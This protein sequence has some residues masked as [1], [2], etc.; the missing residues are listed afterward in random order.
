MV[1]YQC[2]LPAS[3]PKFKK[4][5]SRFQLS[6]LKRNS[7]WQ[8]RCTNNS[9]AQ[10]KHSN[11]TWWSLCNT[12][13]LCYW[14]TGA[15]GK[16]YLLVVPT[17]LCSHLRDLWVVMPPWHFLLKELSL[18]LFQSTGIRIIFI[19]FLTQCLG[20]GRGATALRRHSCGVSCVCLYFFSLFYWLW[21]LE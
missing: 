21:P 11:G 9:P 1:L 16:P 5:L 17:F 6:R 12:D 3:Y 4:E 2:T 15:I 8:L 13:I 10:W 18:S 19:L 14:T 20:E 7:K